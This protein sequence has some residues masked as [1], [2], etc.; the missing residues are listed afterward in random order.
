MRHRVGWWWVYQA[1]EQSPARS[2]VRV[3]KRTIDHPAFIGAKRSIGLPLGQLA[4]WI[5]IHG[6][7]IYGTRPWL[8]YGESAIKVKGGNFK[9]DFK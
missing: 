8:V 2:V 9:E 5:A 3:P 4:D 1:L 7:S 6:E